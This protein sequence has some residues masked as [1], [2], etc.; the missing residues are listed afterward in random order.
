M[1]VRQTSSM[2]PRTGRCPFLSETT[3]RGLRLFFGAVCWCLLSK[4]KDQ[5][6]EDRLWRQSALTG[7]RCK[8]R[9]QAPQAMR[10]QKLN[11]MNGG[12]KK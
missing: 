12:L 6:H 5:Y 11:K 9:K 2:A 4:E 7:P 3:L 8:Q 10:P 1:F